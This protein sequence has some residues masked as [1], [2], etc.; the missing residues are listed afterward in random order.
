[1]AN[2]TI[3]TRRP[4]KRAA[5]TEAGRRE[6]R[7]RLEADPV[8]GRPANENDPGSSMMLAKL[9][10]QPSYAPYYAAF[11]L[12]L[13]W[14]A[15]WFF[16]FSSTLTADGG[17]ASRGL[18]EIMRALALLALPIGIG[19]VVAYFLWRASQLRH[20]SEVLMQS[21]MRLIRPQDIATEGI[22]TIAQAVRSEVDLLVG[23]V[24]HAVQRATALEEIVHKEIAAIERAFGGNEDRIRGLVAGI[25]NQR[26]AL[27]QAG[28]IINNDANPLLTRLE[29][30]TQNLDSIIGNAHATLGRLEKGMRDTTVDL[31]RAIDEVAGR[32]AAAGEEIVGQTSQLER[33]SSVM[34]GEMRDFSRHLASQIEQLTQVTGTLGAESTE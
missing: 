28:L 31:A 21:A 19:W 8:R 30:N 9:R 10:R 27:H 18:P 17:V 7:V 24:E 1:M 16:T 29:A 13:T 6:P 25:E 15:G 5:N 4:D 20:V 34:T 14:I 3:E 33:T 26:T 32:A 22:T 11:F 2:N 23:G 12:S